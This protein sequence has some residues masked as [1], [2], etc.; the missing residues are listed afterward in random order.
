MATKGS[1]QMQKQVVVTLRQVWAVRRM[2]PA[3]LHDQFLS[4]TDIS[5]RVF[6]TH[7]STVSNCN[8]SHFSAYRLQSIIEIV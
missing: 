5:N 2:L 6:G 8:V 7:V 3:K 4:E 1:L